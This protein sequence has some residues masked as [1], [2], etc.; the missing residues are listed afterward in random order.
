MTVLYKMT[1]NNNSEHVGCRKWLRRVCCAW[2]RRAVT[3][4][5]WAIKDSWFAI[6]NNQ[7][8][9]LLGPNGAGKVR[10]VLSP[11]LSVLSAHTEHGLY[12]TLGQ[13]PLIMLFQH[14]SHQSAFVQP[15][16]YNTGHLQPF[17]VPLYCLPSYSSS[18]QPVLLMLLIP[19]CVLSCLTLTLRSAVT[20]C[21][22]YNLQ[23]TSASCALLVKLC[24]KL[25][26]VADNYHQLLDGRHP[27]IRRGC[28]GVWGGPEQQWGHGP[29]SLH[30]V[31]VSPV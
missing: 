16:P 14:N 27:G 9:C 23:R 7:L 24:S 18:C 17:I 28:P 19:H 3:K 10:P 13:C 15:P 5:Y 20:A 12:S 26:L 6:E 22:L 11:L 21:L 29:H 2:R 31:G 4:D 30:D 1:L 25:Y 8:F